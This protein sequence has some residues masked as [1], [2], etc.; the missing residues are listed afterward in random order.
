MV[1]KENHKA[2]LTNPPPEKGVSVI[3]TYL[4]DEGWDAMRPYVF[5]AEPLKLL[6]KAPVILIE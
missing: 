3:I 1:G 2:R 5:F 4:G 6:E